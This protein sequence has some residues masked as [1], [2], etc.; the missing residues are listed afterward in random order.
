MIAHP[1]HHQP[2]PP[3]M[4]R[5]SIFDTPSYHGNGTALFLVILIIAIFGYV[6]HQDYLDEER[7]RCAQKQL[8]FNPDTKTCQHPEN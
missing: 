7:E 5:N 2:K 1:S 4:P 3:P 6:S 8:V